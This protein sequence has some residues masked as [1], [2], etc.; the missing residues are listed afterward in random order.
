MSLNTKFVAMSSDGGIIGSE[1]KSYLKSFC[2]NY[3]TEEFSK[4][5]DLAPNCDNTRTIFPWNKTQKEYSMINFDPDVIEHR[6]TFSEIDQITSSIKGI[7]NYDFEPVIKRKRL[8]AGLLYLLP[9]ITILMF[10]LCQ[11]EHW[12][13]YIGFELNIG[14][15]FIPIIMLQIAWILIVNQ[16]MRNYFKNIMKEREISIT[17]LLEGWNLEKF[18][19]K[20]LEWTAGKYGA[21][22][23]LNCQFRQNDGF[24][25]DEN[26][27]RFDCILKDHQEDMQDTKDTKNSFD[28]SL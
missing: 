7:K 27:I 14:V 5:W 16:Q 20:Y 15:L 10:V 6:V 9:I 23:E 2:E 18:H 24:D 25:Y 4:I 1:N 28:I 17:K 8:V 19:C 22:L 21:W 13:L 3:M 12:D 26:Q 11:K